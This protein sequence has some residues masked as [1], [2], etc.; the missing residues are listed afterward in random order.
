MALDAQWYDLMWRGEKTHE[1]RRRYLTGVPTQWFVYLS[2]PAARLCAIIDLD[3]AI[4]DTPEK[5]AQIADHTRPGNGATVL[6]YLAKDGKE[7]GYALPM[8]RVREFRGIGAQELS[9]ILDGFHP[10]RGYTMVDRHPTWRAV[11][12]K[13]LIMPPTREITIPQPSPD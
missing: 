1:F 2:A 12:D 10:P 7:V 3:P 13:L 6:P 5:I 4:E 8:R 11:C 9:Q